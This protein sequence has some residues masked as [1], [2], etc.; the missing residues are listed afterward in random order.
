LPYTNIN[1]CGI[2]K[3]IVSIIVCIRQ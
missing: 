3:L 2:S 1:I